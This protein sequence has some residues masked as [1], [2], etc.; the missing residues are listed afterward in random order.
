MEV[1]PKRWGLLLLIIV[2]VLVISDGLYFLLK[3]KA[4]FV[5]PVPAEPSFKIIYYTPTPGPVTPSST[6]SATPK[7]KKAPAS[8]P[9]SIVTV[10]PAVKLQL[11]LTP[12]P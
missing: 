1:K 6:P 12:T 9:I 11:T 7:V 3:G 4:K 8:T 10:T 2:I 5:T